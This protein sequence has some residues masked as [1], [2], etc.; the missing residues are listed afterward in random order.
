MVGRIFHEPGVELDMGGM[1]MTFTLILHSTN[2][3]STQKTLVLS[4]GA[5]SYR[6]FSGRDC[7]GNDDHFYP[8]KAKV[9]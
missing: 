5:N 8:R 1:V 9:G 6:N 3:L 7:F 2:A 4:H